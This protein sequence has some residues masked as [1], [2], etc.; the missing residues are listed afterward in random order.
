MGDKRCAGCVSGDLDC[1]A[2][3][4]YVEWVRD[5][6][7]G[8]APG[9]KSCGACRTKNR[10]CG[11]PGAPLNP[12]RKRKAEEGEAVKRKK[13]KPVIES[14]P[15]SESEWV[16][17][18]DFLK[19]VDDSLY[20]VQSSVEDMQVAVVDVQHRLGEMNEVGVDTRAVADDLSERLT[21]MTN[22]TLSLEREQKRQGQM[23]R[24][25]MEKCDSGKLAEWTKEWNAED[26]R[27]K[28]KRERREKAAEVQAEKDR[29]KL[30][31]ERKRK[32]AERRD[33]LEGMH[34]A[35]YTEASETSSGLGSRSSVPV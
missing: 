31:R 17:P 3:S 28:E 32:D 34:R 18:R 4:D 29:Q 16:P 14:E 9:R 21:T 11:I 1:V 25:L 23:I 24:A 22:R 12:P 35:R 5:G 19:K 6:C 15:E 20:M 27:W 33:K 10:R 30:E 2:P 7:S 26:A 13:S 8:R